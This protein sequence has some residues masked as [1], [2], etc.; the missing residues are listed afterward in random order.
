MQWPP[1][2]SSGAPVTAALRPRLCPSTE[3]ERR[4]LGREVPKDRKIR[5]RASWR[6]PRVCWRSTVA[7]QIQE[8]CRLPKQTHAP[9]WG[10]AR[11][12]SVSLQAL[13]GPW[14]WFWCQFRLFRAG[15][16]KLL[17]LGLKAGQIGGL[18]VQ[19]FLPCSPAWSELIADAL[20]VTKHPWGKKDGS[21]NILK[22]S[23]A[24]SPPAPRLCRVSKKS[25]LQGI[26]DCL[27]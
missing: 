8:Q 20:W 1:M 24:P 22:H 11:R 25:H 21:P 7:E 2:P 6:G 27:G 12:S 3:T 16:R 14:S 17:S 19:V 5:V 4:D 10:A 15:V 13:P 26:G 9:G 23:L 18:P